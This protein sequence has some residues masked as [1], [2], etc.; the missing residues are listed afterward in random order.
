MEGFMNEYYVKF[1]TYSGIVN[2]ISEEEIYET[3]GSNVLEVNKSKTYNHKANVI[4]DEELDRYELEYLEFEKK[5]RNREKE[6]HNKKL[7]LLNK[8][9]SFARSSKRIPERDRQFIFSLYS[10]YNKTNHF[11]HKQDLVFE[12][13]LEKFKIA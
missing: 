9:L 7:I 13:L 2:A 5:Q 11:S 4:S 12:E 6:I 10:V 1:K 3:Y 8:L